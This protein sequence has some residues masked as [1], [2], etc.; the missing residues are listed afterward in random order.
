MGL[1]SACIRVAQSRIDET[2]CVMAT[3]RL[4]FAGPR[5]CTCDKKCVIEVSQGFLP[6]GQQQSEPPAPTPLKRR[7]TVAQM[8]KPPTTPLKRRPTVAETTR[9]IQEQLQAR[10][11][12]R[13]NKGEEGAKRARAEN[14]LKS[15]CERG[16][17]GA[18]SDKDDKPLKTRF[19][20][21]HQGR[22]VAAKAA[23]RNKKGGKG[24]PCVNVEWSRNQVMCR[25]ADRG[26]RARCVCVCV[27]VCVC[28]HL[29][30]CGRFFGFFRRGWPRIRLVSCGGPQ[31]GVFPN[32]SCFTSMVCGHFCRHVSQGQ[33]LGLLELVLVHVE[34][35]GRH[36]LSVWATGG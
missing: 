12:G 29:F 24:F 1:P 36:E 15:R 28:G 34:F 9:L 23:V 32:S 3:E 6:A 17:Q 16:H 26:G 8:S 7:T 21:G 20:S 19:D 27:C 35:E 10:A 13:S 14:S 30:R 18:K 25:G 2:L 11:G 4:P 33:D 31:V 22:K 5:R